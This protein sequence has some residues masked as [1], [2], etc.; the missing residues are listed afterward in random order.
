MTPQRDEFPP[1]AADRITASG[2]ES[3]EMSKRYE[4]GRV[5]EPPVRQAE[6]WVS[7]CEVDHFIVCAACGQPIDCR[8]LAAVTYH[9]QAVHLPLAPLDATRLVRSP[10]LRAALVSGWRPGPPPSV[11]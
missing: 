4:Q 7:F 2:L 9:E 1:L 10:H 6:G 8:D 3:F 11:H 5:C